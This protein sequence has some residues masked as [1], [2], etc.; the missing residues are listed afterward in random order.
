MLFLLFRKESRRGSAQG[1]AGGFKNKT[2]STAL[3]APLLFLLFRIESCRGSA[4]GG[5]GGFKNKTTSTAL[6]AP[7][8]FFLC[9]KESRRESA[10]AGAGGFKNKTTSTSQRARVCRG[11]P[12][13]NCAETPA[14]KGVSVRS[15]WKS[16]GGTTVPP[17][18]RGL[19]E[20]LERV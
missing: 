4:Q 5:A 15:D 9:R 6:R 7:M 19:P 1:G 14:R 10:L 12:V 8:L 2:T 3:R 18:L 17:F 20:I 11:A 16:D 13:E